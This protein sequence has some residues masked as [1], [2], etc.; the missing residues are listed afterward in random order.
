MSGRV[1]AAR[2]TRTTLAACVVALVL[3]LAALPAA[4]VPGSSLDDSWVLAAEHAARHHLVFGRDFVFT[5]GPFAALTTHL[6]D[7]RTFGWVLLYDLF[8]TLLWL[9]PLLCSRRPLTLAFYASTLLL[10]PVAVDARVAVA[11]FAFTLTAL[12]RPGA[13]ALAAAALLALAALAKFSFALTALPL[14]VILDGQAL[15]TRCRPPLATTAFLAAMALALVLTGQPPFTWPA[16][17]AL[18]GEVIGG[19]SGAM[20]VEGSLASIAIMI[21]AVIAGSLV[22][23]WA[24]WALRRRRAEAGGTT[25]TAA[26]LALC[27]TIFIA[28]KMGYVRADGHTVITWSVIVLAVPPLVAFADAARRLDRCEA[29]LASTCALFAAVGLIAV[30]F[31]FSNPRPPALGFVRERAAAVALAVPNGLGW[32]LQSTW[33]GASAA[34]LAADRKLARPFSPSVRGRVDAVPVYVADVIASGLDYRPRPVPQSYSAY[35]PALQRADAAFFAD[36][37]RA[38]DTLLLGLGSDIDFR[39]PT[40]A[41]GPSL[42]VIAAWYDIAGVDKLGLIL[43]RRPVPRVVSSERTAPRAFGMRQWVALPGPRADAM[44]TAAIDLHRTLAARAMSLLVREPTL[45]IELRYADGGTRS[46]RFIPGMTAVG[47]VLSPMPRGPN[48]DLPGTDAAA[49][50]LVP[51][52][53]PTV[54]RPV[55]A[56]RLRGG[57]AAHLA[58]RGGTVRFETLR[59]GR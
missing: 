6:F 19:Y 17:A 53:R 27:W 46:F 57:S 29:I 11:L 23:G 37:S 31:K 32:A 55:I 5:Y 13:W 24:G 10:V 50:V 1:S 35:T 16:A 26:M 14:L 2:G 45:S 43:R 33:R 49:G 38:P 59:F 54:D 56:F 40:L 51:G 47:T 8:L 7:V 41:A 39:L 36:P 3:V 48:F 4:V 28:F 21:A 42:P 15:V 34:R 30:A 12:R 52:A 25:V 58:F 9:S 44:V 22:I 20:Q 18:I